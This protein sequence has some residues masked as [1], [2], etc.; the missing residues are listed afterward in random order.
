MKLQYYEMMDDKS[1]EYLLYLIEQ[2]LP[3]FKENEF[4]IFLDKLIGDATKGKKSSKSNFG[5]DFVNMSENNDKSAD[6][7]KLN[8]E[9]LKVLFQIF[10]SRERNDNIAIKWRFYQYIKYIMEF[11]LKSVKFNPDP[12]PDLMIDFIIETEENEVFLALCSD[13]LDLDNYKN[14]LENIKDFVKNENLIPDRIIFAMGKSFRNI[15]IDS[16]IKIVNNEIIP[17]LWIEWTEE[18]CPFNKEDLIIVN[19]SELKLAGFNFISTNDLLNYV[20]THTKGGQVSLY[21]QMD[22]FTETGEDEPE[23]ELFWKGILLK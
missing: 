18:N 22:F 20:F 17:E 1:K 2:I 7:S 4:I 14:A 23:V 8:V 19:N 5:K 3:E 12:N 15:P 9:K 6:L 13:I 16:P 21:R 11:N 10:I